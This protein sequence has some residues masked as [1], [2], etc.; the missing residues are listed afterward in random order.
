[1]QLSGV[2]AT[3]GLVLMFSCRQELT[4]CQRLLAS[5]GAVTSVEMFETLTRRY[6]VG[7]WVPLFSF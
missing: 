4:K 2:G 6:Q 7:A 3:E 1:M 5:S